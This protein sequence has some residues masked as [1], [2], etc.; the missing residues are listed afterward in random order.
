MSLQIVSNKKYKITLFPFG[1]NNLKAKTGYVYSDYAAHER[2]L[3]TTADMVG[4]TLVYFRIRP[5]DANSPT[6]FT[7]IPIQNW[8]TSSSDVKEYVKEVMKLLLFHYTDHRITCFG[9]DRKE[10]LLTI[11]ATD[12]DADALDNMSDKSAVDSSVVEP[13]GIRVQF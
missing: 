7:T 12:A 13:N 9:A 8:N 10:W 1:D 5:T 11:E 4:G 3:Q 2:I 6:V